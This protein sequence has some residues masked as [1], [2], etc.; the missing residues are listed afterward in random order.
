ME[1][2]HLKDMDKN[3]QKKLAELDEKI[4]GDSKLIQLYRRDPQAFIETLELEPEEKALFKV[5]FDEQ[6]TRNCECCAVF[7][8]SC[9]V[10]CGNFGGTAVG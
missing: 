7:F 9:G 5:K 10:G 3:F 2:K 1:Q 8:G 6:P 4:A